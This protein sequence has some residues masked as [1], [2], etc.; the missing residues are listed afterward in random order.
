MPDCALV[1]LVALDTLPNYL[2][3]LIYLNLSFVEYIF[4]SLLIVIDI[5]LFED[6]LLLFLWLIS[7][8]LF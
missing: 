4:S 6:N 2:C 8:E 7:L 3:W 1:L 5:L